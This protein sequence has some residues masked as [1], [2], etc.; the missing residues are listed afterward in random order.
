MKRLLVI[1]LFVSTNVTYFF[2]L[3]KCSAVFNKTNIP[4][5]NLAAVVRLLPTFFF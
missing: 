2:V 1:S 3:V 5:L 4:Q